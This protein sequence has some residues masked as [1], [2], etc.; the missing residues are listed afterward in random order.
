MN[1]AQQNALSKKRVLYVDDEVDSLTV[2]K[3]GLEHQGDF[4]VDVVASPEELSVKQHSDLDMYDLIVLDI[5]MP[6]TNGFELYG[7]IRGR[8]DPARTKICFFTAYQNYLDICTSL[9][10]SWKGNCFLAKP[11]SISVFAAS[12]RKLMQ[13]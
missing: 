1:I 3:K 12:L 6:R 5:R 13:S 11:M 8:I 4:E 2:I 10:P 9:F 7:M